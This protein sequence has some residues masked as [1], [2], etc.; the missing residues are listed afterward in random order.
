MGVYGNQLA[1]FP[2]LFQK[3]QVFEKAP[4]ITGGLEPKGESLLIKGI[5]QNI[6]TTSIDAESDSVV[7]VAR[8]ALFTKTKID[9]RYQY[10]LVEG[11]LYRVK[12]ANNYTKEGSFYVYQ[13][14]TVQG[15]TDA[16]TPN[17]YAHNNIGWQ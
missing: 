14:E 8:P 11:V 17:P 3:L 2:E 16:Q 4:V 10:M 9:Q 5:I 15:L 12:Q 1:Y 7:V 6:K 13:I